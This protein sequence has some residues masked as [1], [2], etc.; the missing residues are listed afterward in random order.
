M[1][2]VMTLVVRDEED[3]LAAQLH[4]HRAQGVNFF[5][6]LDHRS[7]DRTR[8]IL[9][10]YESRGW[11]RWFA[12]DSLQRDQ[13]R[14]VTALA[15]RAFHDHQADWVINNDAD[16]FWWCETGTLNAYLAQIPTA[17]R[18][19]YAPRTN[20]WAPDPPISTAPF[21]QKQVLEQKEPVNFLGEPLSGKICHRGEPDIIV[22]HGNHSVEPMQPED[23]A[24]PLAANPLRILH[25]P[26]RSYLQFE[27][28]VRNGG[29]SWAAN[30]HVSLA[31][32]KGKRFLYERFLTGQLPDFYRQW[33]GKN[34]P[35]NQRHNR[36]FCD[37][38]TKLNMS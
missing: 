9:S 8:D 35:Q 12:I 18:L 11:L 30:P 4:Y 33:Q 1:K 5:L 16:E 34:H 19:V 25:F 15:Q 29:G 14:W 28:K 10:D 2:L 31:T 26:L 27:Q 20:F 7:V 36:D 37:F 6:V 17:Y 22:H 24:P 13:G 21:W 32:G 38:M 23:I 3:I